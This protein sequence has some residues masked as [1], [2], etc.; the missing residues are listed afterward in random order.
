MTDQ[1][2]ELKSFVK[3]IADRPTKKDVAL[4]IETLLKAVRAMRDTL[5][6]DMDSMSSSHFSEMKRMDAMLKSCEKD[7]KG[8]CS[9]MGKSSKKDMADMKESLEM[10]IS[11]VQEQIDSMEE[12]DSTEIDA[13]VADLKSKLEAFKL[14]TAEETRDKLESLKDDERLDKSAI[15]GIEELEKEF[16]SFKTSAKGVRLVGGARGIQ[17]FVDG[18]KKGLVNELNLIAGTNMTITYTR[19]SGRNDILLDAGGATG[20]FTKLSATGAVDGSNKDFT[21]TSA[22]S[23][24]IVDG[25]RAMQKTSS[26]GTINWTGTT[27]VSLTV[28][29]QND[30]YGF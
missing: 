25:G 21:F 3:F 29:P 9:D 6:S 22:P 20:S 4:A 28:A 14:P 17:L 11:K 2:Q 18:T 12:Y 10:K 16:D 27:N 13:C 26:D 24:I 1:A 8:M 7:M 19:S 23:I 5:K 15:K 30:I